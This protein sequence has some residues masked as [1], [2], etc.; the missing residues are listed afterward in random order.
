[1]GSYIW[2]VAC[3][4]IAAVACTDD[5]VRGISDFSLILL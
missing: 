5:K 4:K 2:L 3:L 1:M